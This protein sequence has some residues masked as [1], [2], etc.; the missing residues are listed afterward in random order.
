M[1][2]IDADASITYAKEGRPYKE[3]KKG[4]TIFANGDVLLA[5]ITPCFENGK[6]SQVRV[7]TSVGFGSTEFHVIRPHLDKLDGRY[8]VHFLR[9]DKIRVAGERRMTGSAGQRR[10]P[11]SFLEGLELPLP[12]LREQRRIAAILDKVED[13]RAKRSEALAHLDRLARSI[14]VEM[15][16]DPRT[17]P[18]NWPQVTLGDVILDGPQNGLYKPASAYG[19]GTLIL[20]IDGFYDGVMADL[21]TLRRLRLESKE[22]D[23]YGL[24]EGEVVINRVNSPEYLGK[25]AIIPALSEPVVFES[26]MMRFSL[27]KSRTVPEYIVQFLQTPYIKAQILSASKNAVN[28]SSINQQDVK[29]LTLNLPPLSIQYEFLERLKATSH[30]RRELAISA[31]TADSLF[32][33]L[34]HRAFRGEL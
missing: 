27:R 1:S 10:V 6:I 7:G 34:Q 13:L 24:H 29:A 15:F 22:L 26:N 12:P 3:V 30:M 4:Y 19:S 2:A 14:F 17:N 28:Q 23:L 21:A 8:L 33:S 32:A 18:K 11:K 25:S 5:K 20:R 31:G 16:G 9:Q